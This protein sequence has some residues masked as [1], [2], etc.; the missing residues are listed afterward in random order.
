M[1]KLSGV[2]GQGM[3]AQEN[4]PDLMIYSGGFFCDKDKAF[5]ETIRSTPASELSGLTNGFVDPRLPEMLF[6]YRAR[7]F[8]ETLS[9]KE[10]EQ[11]KEFC[12]NRLTSKD[13][14]GG[15]VITDYL[16]ILAKL[17]EQKDSNIRFLESLEDYTKSL[18]TSE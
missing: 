11:W 14:G 13:A 4:D 3:F 1:E 15:M 6:R 2:Y 10:K 17:K 7:N 18:V 5:M 16:G 9:K 8:P 12:L